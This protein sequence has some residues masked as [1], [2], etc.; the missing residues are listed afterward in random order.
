MEWLL[1]WDYYFKHFCFS[2]DSSSIDFKD[3]LL[4]IVL[5]DGSNKVEVVIEVESI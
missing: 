5:R 2:V 4:C 3:C 1:K